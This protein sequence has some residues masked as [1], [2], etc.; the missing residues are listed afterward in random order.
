MCFVGVP[1][2]NTTDFS[3]A[4]TEK[5]IDI[6]K[7]KSLSIS[8]AKEQSN[9]STLSSVLSVTL[10]N[11]PPGTTSP[12]YT[13]NCIAGFSDSDEAKVSAVVSVKGMH[14][15]VCVFFKTLVFVQSYLIQCKGVRLI[16]VKNIKCTVLQISG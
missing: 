11:V 10:K 8:K 15:C 6:S 2:D 12:T 13:F 3:F 14:L 5:S 1:T 4:W 9:S 7:D 16:V